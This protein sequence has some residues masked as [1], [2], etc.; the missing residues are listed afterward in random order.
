MNSAKAS[1]AS[2]QSEHVN[3]HGDKGDLRSTIYFD[4]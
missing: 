4:F 3:K 1:P 2:S